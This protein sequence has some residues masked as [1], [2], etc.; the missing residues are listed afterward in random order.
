VPDRVNVE[1]RGSGR[2][3]F[4]IEGTSRT[5]G[6]GQ[7]AMMTTVTLIE[8]SHAVLDKSLFDVP[9]GY[10][11]ALPRL[12]G[13]FDMTRPDTIANRVAVYW[14]DVTGLARDFLRF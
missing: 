7:A 8:L 5:H 10:R 9:A 14:Q 1:V 6:R 3:G 2:R 4:T 13:G 11:P 12:I